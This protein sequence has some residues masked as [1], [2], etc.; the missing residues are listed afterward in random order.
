MLM[1]HLFV[2]FKIALY[3]IDRYNN[4]DWQRK[5]YDKNLLYFIFNE[6]E[7]ICP[8]PIALCERLETVKTLHDVLRIIT[9]DDINSHY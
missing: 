1:R 7:M 3:I 8:Q 5:L 6:I 4:F 9:E 2:F